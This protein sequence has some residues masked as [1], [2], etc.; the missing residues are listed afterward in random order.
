MN[1]SERTSTRYTVYIV[2]RTCEAFAVAWEKKNTP[3][4]LY[5]ADAERAFI[6]NFIQNRARHRGDESKSAGSQ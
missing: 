6:E 2:R 4:L 3:A 1:R 5:F